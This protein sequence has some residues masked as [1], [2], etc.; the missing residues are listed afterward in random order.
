MILR[1]SF[2][3][4]WYD[5]WIG[6]YVD[7]KGRA[8]YVCPL[9]CCVLKLNWGRKYWN[10]KGSVWKRDCGH[11]SL[12][13]SIDST[14]GNRFWMVY[15]NGTMCTESEGFTPKFTSAWKA[16]EYADSQMPMEDD[17]TYDNA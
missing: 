14:T 2:F 8:I 9:P 10:R 13:R 11:V 1:L 16:M 15:T 6:A 12:V 4:A 3:L 17:F 7:T 5:I